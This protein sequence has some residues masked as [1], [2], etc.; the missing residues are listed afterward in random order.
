MNISLGIRTAET[1]AIYF[2]KAQSDAIRRFLPQKAQTLDEALV[3][4]YDTLLPDATSYGRTILADERYIGDVWCYG[5]DRH[6]EPQA[7]ISYCIFDTTCWNQGIASQA[8]ALFLEDIKAHLP[9]SVF[10][11]FTYAENTASRR[12]LEKNGFLLMEA[13]EEDGIESCY[14]QLG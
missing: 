10:G 5:I 13:F 14:Y 4:Y 1:V 6:D 2:E 9:L 12:V 7:M 8:V 3:D 11:A